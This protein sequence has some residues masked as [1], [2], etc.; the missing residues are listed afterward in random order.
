MPSNPD[1]IAAHYL[2][3]V[4]MFLAD[5]LQLTRKDRQLTHLRVLVFL[6]VVAFFAIGW[7]T[8]IVQPWYLPGVFAAIGFVALVTYHDSVDR[9]LQR[10]R[11]LR[12]INDQG[13]ARLA[14][15]WDRLPAP[16]IKAPDGH[17]ATATDLDLFGRASL[18]QLVSCATTPIGRDILRDWLVEPAS[19]DEIKARQ[20]AVAELINREA[21]REE[22]VLE[23]RLLAGDATERFV[24]WASGPAWLHERPWLIWLCRIVPA[25]GLLAFLL[26]L[27]RLISPDV[28]FAII[29]AVVVT[30]I[31]ISVLFS[32]NVHDIFARVN[33]RQG[34]V[35]RYLQMF[36]LMYSMPESSGKLA[37][38]KRE[39]TE[40][41]G[42]V[43]RRMRDL[44]FVMQLANISHSAM[45]FIF[46]Y[47]PLQAGLLYDFHILNLLEKWQRDCGAHAR[48]WFEALGQFE[49]LASL[50]TLAY[51]H[52]AWT[53]PEVD[54]AA[55]SIEASGLG[56]PLLPDA[57][58]VNNDVQVGVA[59]SF[60][61]ITG[62]N[63]SGKSTLLRSI[64]VNIVLAQAGG[65]VCASKLRLPPVQLATSIR[66]RDSL[67]DG[68]SFYMAELMRLKEIVDQ[69]V[70]FGGR[71][72]CTLVYLLD[73]ILQGTNSQ[74]RRIAVVR[75]LSHLVRH[76]AIG[77]IS[78]HDLDLA[79]SDALVGQ[80]RPVHFRETLHDH[81]AENP[82]TFDYRLREGVA[83]T[84]NA[85]KLL[86][87]V[88]L[89]N[90]SS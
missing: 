50:A 57:V 24:Q 66:V 40:H 47:L 72:D 36:R 22:L 6:T 39:V 56:H 38:I 28:G 8:M 29:L 83:T 1:P 31:L 5:E 78:T 90:A 43:L 73:E 19:C 26:S 82:M 44:Q 79:A 68:V 27:V 77:A 16:T 70:D 49:S 61:L 64:G 14:R 53:F 84:T 67:E 45:L 87:I 23:G 54:A 75:V 7:I 65:P 89:G 13:L 62:S 52:P 86:E 9:R 48:N 3:R 17:V 15:A 2:L 32:G 51:D 21:L 63:M 69:A 37:E 74:E 11:H 59:G 60:L 34:E 10:A 85:L 88:G 4:E 25:T 35:R 81:D 30:N 33:T 42:G 58:R 12:L 20:Q 41:G 71:P 55:T 80:F 76:G 46:L 18:Y